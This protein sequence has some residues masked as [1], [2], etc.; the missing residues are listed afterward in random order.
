[1]LKISNKI[2]WVDPGPGALVHAR[3]RKAPVEHVSLIFISHSHLDHVS[4]INPVV[5]AITL[6]PQVNLTLI[7]PRSVVEDKVLY[8]YLLPRV[9]EKVFLEEK[10]EYQLSP[11]R[12]TWFPLKHTVPCYGFRISKLDKT[13]ITY[14]SDT[15]YFEDLSHYASSTEVLIINV[16]F[17][18]KLN[19]GMH[20]SIPELEKILMKAD[21]KPR[22]TLITHLG[23]RYKTDSLP[24][25]E[26]S[27][28]EKLGTR[29]LFAKDNW[30]FFL[31]R[32]E[33]NLPLFRN[34]NL[35]EKFQRER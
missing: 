32:E 22:F 12:I 13:L 7:A 8:E 15:S 18:Y 11:L 16:L 20:L 31:K 4:D 27:L 2:I 28:T 3:R 35:Q 10:S 19:I 25:I 21:P 29:V 26:R 1:M 6:K 17:P 23:G 9:K 34:H 24:E 30:R 5:E 33:R 14:I